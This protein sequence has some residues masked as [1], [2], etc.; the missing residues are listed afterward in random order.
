MNSTE[1]TVFTL[2]RMAGCA[3]PDT[4]T[5]AG[6]N[7]LRQIEAATEEAIGWHVDNHEP[8]DVDPAEIADGCVPMPTHEIWATFVDLAAYQEDISEYG[9]GTSD[10][11]K[12]ASVALYTIG[13]RLAAAIIAEHTDDGDA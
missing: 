2:A 11:E 7:Y 10:L 1:R 3:D 13:A 4:S 9:Y 8:G 5:S 6:A 12:L